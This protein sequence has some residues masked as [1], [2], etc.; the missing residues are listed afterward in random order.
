MSSIATTSHW[1]QTA[2]ILCSRNCGIEV[3]VQGREMKRI[4]GDHSHPISEGYLCQKAQRLNYY[5]NHS[6]RLTSP[7]RRRE[8][9]SFEE[10]SWDTA[11]SEIAS[12]LVHL[13]DAFGGQSLAYFGGGGQGNHL[14]GPYGKA[15]RTAMRTRNYYS[16]LAQE[17]TGGFWVDGR[18]Y[19]KQNCHPS[20]DVENAEVVVFIG[21]NPWQSHGIRNARVVLREIQKDPKRQMIVIDPRRTETAEMADLHLQVRP[22]TDAFLMGALLAVIVRED[23]AAHEFIDKHTTGFSGV[24]EALL[25]VPIEAF[26]ERA[27]IAVEDVYKAAQMIAGAASCAVRTDLGIEQTLNSTLNAYLRALISLLTGNF[28]RPGGNNL[29]TSLVPLIGHSPEGPRQQRS[30]VNGF[31]FIGNLLPPNI[32]PSEIASDHPNRTRGLVVDSA[33]PMVTMADTRAYREAFAKLDLLV[34]IDVAMTETARAAHYVLPASSQF[35]KWEATFFNLEFPKNA[36]HLRKPLF[37]P[38]PGTMAEAEIYTRLVTEMGELPSEFPELEQAAKANRLVFAGAFQNLIATK[39]ELADY[40]PIILYRTLGP[41]LPEGAAAAA[42]LWATAHGFARKEPEAVRRAGH[43]GEGPM[44]GEAL[45]EA[46]LASR[47]GVLFSVN[48]YDETWR[49]IKHEDGLIH[50]EIPEMLEALGALDPHPP[51]VAGSYPFVLVAGERRSYNA[52]TIYRDPNWR[53]TDRDGALKVHPADAEAC[54]LSD[55]GWARC[56]SKRGA[57]LVRVEV[58]GQ[59]SRGQVTLPHGYGMEH[60]GDDGKRSRT[61]AHI[62]ELTSAEDRDPIAGTPYHKYVPVRL[63]PAEA[64]GA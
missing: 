57:V 48:D 44:L 51:A 43:T 52:N 5:Q 36:F 31:P 13:R 19:G 34:V 63:S 60:P 46:I 2:C 9:G 40:A 56:E 55:G 62:N 54:G 38:L 27:G 61:G 10:V 64:A 7:L 11:I 21:T 26:A 53:K 49:Y 41:T 3:E 8:D 1:I 30:A 24:R 29:H 37:E 42:F 33:N 47:S 14:A 35:E 28:A 15:L 17:K 58:S 39:P 50:L 20:E 23:R 16:A 25:K 22:G 6:D 18:L 12:K 32:L 4:R 59:V 45:F